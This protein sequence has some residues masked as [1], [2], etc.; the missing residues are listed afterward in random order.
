MK[1]F[2]NYLLSVVLLCSALTGRSLAA[3]YKSGIIYNMQG[4]KASAWS[5]TSNAEKWLHQTDLEK[6][7]VNTTKKTDPLPFFR[8]ELIAVHGS[9][10]VKATK[11][12]N[13]KTATF[14]STQ[15]Y[16][17]KNKSTSTIKNLKVGDIFILKLKNA[18]GYAILKISKIKDDGS[19]L[20]YEGN[21]LDY[22]GFE[23]SILK[24]KTIEAVAFLDDEFE[25]EDQPY[26]EPEAEM[27]IYPNPVIDKI[28]V[29]FRKPTDNIGWVVMI[30]NTNGDKVFKSENIYDLHWTNDFKDLPAGRYILSVLKSDQ[31]YLQKVIDKNDAKLSDLYQ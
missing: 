13:S 27:L 3:E 31:V 24:P 14:E 15:A 9:S 29:K 8:R 23:Y 19:S 18:E 25:K 28:H 10:F 16:F 20:L 17:G 22:I 1:T 11:K 30:E 21:N 7:I 26:W 4:P 2:F 12:F 6:D 5:L